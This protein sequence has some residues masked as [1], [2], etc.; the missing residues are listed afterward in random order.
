MEATSMQAEASSNPTQGE[1]WIRKPTR[2]TKIA[3]S[4]RPPDSTAPRKTYLNLPEAAPSAPAEATPPPTQA[5]APTPAAQ[6][7]SR[8]G[9]SKPPTALQRLRQMTPPLPRRTI[10]EMQN[11]RRRAKAIG[12]DRLIRYAVD[13]T[14]TTKD[15]ADC[16]AS[17]YNLTPEERRSMLQKLRLIR[18][19][20]RQ[21]CGEVR[22]K[23][24]IGSADAN[25][26]GFLDWLDDKLEAVEARYSKSD[27][28]M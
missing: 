18:K 15:I 20:Q 23:S 14:R 7:S 24:K 26:K 16:L 17:R 2:P 19:S 11:A 25:R 4:K 3:G 13:Y 28:D 22:R 9:S 1:P 10:E 27:E 6:P 12:S 21:I 8:A 5:P